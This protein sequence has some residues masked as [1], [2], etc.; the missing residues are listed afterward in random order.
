MK[1]A[2]FTP[3]VVV[4]FLVKSAMKSKSSGRSVPP[5][6]CEYPELRYTGCPAANAA[7]I[8]LSVAFSSRIVTVGLPFPSSFVRWKV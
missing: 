8:S 2:S 7:R 1:V 5:Q 4:V 3:S 6:R